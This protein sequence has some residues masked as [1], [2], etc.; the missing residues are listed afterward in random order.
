MMPLSR[1]GCPL[2][3]K[4]P[5]MG[6]TGQYDL[7]KRG[8]S[9]V[10]C[11]V[12]EYGAFEQRFAADRTIQEGR[13]RPDS[14]HSERGVVNP[15][16]YSVF[17]LM[18][19]EEEFDFVYNDFLKP[20]FES[21]E[22]AEF[23]VTRA[24]DI[25]NQRSILNDIVVQIAQSD[26]VIADLTGCN[27]NVF[28]E[29]GLAHALRRPVILLTQDIEDVPFDLKTY[30]TLEY[31]AHFVKIQNAKATLKDYAQKFARD[32]MQFGNPVIDYLPNAQALAKVEQELEASTEEDDRG[33]LDH[34]I[35]VVEGY[36][37]LATIATNIT[38]AMQRDVRQPMEGATEELGKLVAGGRMADPRAAQAVARRLAKHIIK[39]SV[40]LGRANIE[41]A[42]MLRNT[43]YSL[44]FAASFAVA[45]DEQTDIG[46]E[47][48]LNHL[49][50]F[51][52][53]AINARDSCIDLAQTSDDLP[54]IER[55]LNRALGDQ[56]EELRHFGSN[57]DRTIA[58]V[59]RA[60]TIWKRRRRSNG[61]G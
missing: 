11:N 60:L 5:N 33:L 15:M 39:F 38:G 22:D 57:L 2:S 42:E 44:E 52:Q 58:S 55:R 26:L 48:Q 4:I 59:T 45:Q 16:A 29:L 14:R 30:R 49:R 46:L 12:R 20:V 40:N 19:F 21:L 35:D 34:I 31:D 9:E 61:K 47:E 54:R 3:R 53:T 50:E 51:R 56:S 24:D 10:T 17:V 7:R 32:E 28:Y 23:Q 25:G 6:N 43:E 41:Y 36:D 8:I 13:R 1:L 37:Q 18:P 27:P